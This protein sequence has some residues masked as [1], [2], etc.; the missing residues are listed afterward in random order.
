MLIQRQ[1]KVL[2]KAATQNFNWLVGKFSGQDVYIV[3]GGASLHGFDF[4]KLDD[5]NVI[6]VNHSYLYCKTDILV[7]LDGSFFNQAGERGHDFNT[8]SFN[9]IAGPASCIS[10]SDKIFVVSC[11]SEPTT[12]TPHRLFGSSS[13]T[14]LAIN[15]ALYT[16]AKRIFLLGLD[17]KFTNGLGHFY[18]DKWKHK[19]DNAEIKYKRIVPLYAK[20]KRFSNIYNCNQDSAVRVFPFI[21][22]DDALGDM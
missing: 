6:S 19:A 2:Q 3:A 10:R 13:S 1:P 12:T 16:K 14:L 22:I 5:K 7:A 20:Y 11:T 18:S 8:Y 15:A 9:T 17:G 4:K 21:G